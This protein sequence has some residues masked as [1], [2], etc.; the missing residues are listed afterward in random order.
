[1]GHNKKL[2]EHATLLERC[3]PRYLHL[4]IRN[5]RRQSILE[6][7]MVDLHRE[8]EKEKEMRVDPNDAHT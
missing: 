4:L 8:R 6:G 7:D 1:M 3:I 2:L 5:S